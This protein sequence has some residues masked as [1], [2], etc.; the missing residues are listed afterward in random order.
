MN[1]Y[2]NIMLPNNTTTSA[3]CSPPH[4]SILSK[5]K[6]S[7]VNNNNNY[8]FNNIYKNVG[9]KHYKN[10]LI[11]SLLFFCYV[12]TKSKNLPHY[13]GY[14]TADLHTWVGLWRVRI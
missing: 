10:T 8:N 9:L 12:K 11:Y 5:G 7:C 14:Q 6:Y 2:N 1:T 4:A 3:T 13:S